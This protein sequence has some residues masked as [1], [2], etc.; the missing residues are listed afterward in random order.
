M[1]PGIGFRGSSSPT[2]SDAST[3]ATAGRGVHLCGPRLSVLRGDR[4]MFVGHDLLSRRSRRTP[5]LPFF[6][7]YTGQGEGFGPFPVRNFQA[8]QQLVLSLPG[9]GQPVVKPG[10]MDVRLELAEPP[11]SMTKFSAGTV[12]VKFE[13]LRSGSSFV[14]VPPT[15]GDWT[16]ST[17]ALPVSGIFEWSH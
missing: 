3:T 10:T 14:M 7:A 11:V 2:S 6:P 9:D 13:T 12:T 1:T 15:D 16:G 8:F 17:G 4:V 5:R